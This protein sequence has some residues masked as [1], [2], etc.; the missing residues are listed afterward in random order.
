MMQKLSPFWDRFAAIQAHLG[1]STVVDDVAWGREHAL[2]KM[3]EA[4]EILSAE[5]VERA[6]QSESRRERHHGA[7]RRRH[8]AGVANATNDPVQMLEGRQELELVRGQVTDSEWTL[9]NALGVGSGYAELAAQ[10][11]VTEGTVRVRALRARN[12]ALELL[13][14]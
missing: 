6:V 14:A 7:I 11:G 2:N 8:A 13:A 9:L 1:S 10:A 12:K 3:L 4:H 5:D